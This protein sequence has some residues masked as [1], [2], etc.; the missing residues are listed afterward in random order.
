MTGR[1]CRCEKTGIHWRI[2]LWSVV[3][4]LQCP[5]RAM[6]LERRACLAFRLAGTILFSSLMDYWC[7]TY[8]A[9][10]IL[11]LFAFISTNSSCWIRGR[12]K[13]LSGSVEE[14]LV[15]TAD[16][17]SHFCAASEGGGILVFVPIA[18]G[19]MWQAKCHMLPCDS[20]I[21]KK[22]EMMDFTM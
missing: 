14:G 3:E 2:D 13:E 7:C 6:C 10:Y 22:S 5:L 4:K 19:L 9:S 21:L 11:L 18:L 8:I 12:E 16:F 17:C 20:Y 1:T 15:F